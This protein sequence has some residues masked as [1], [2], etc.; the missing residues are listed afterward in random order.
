L[1][2]VKKYISLFGGDPDN[3][4]VM[5]QS[6]GAASIMHHITSYGGPRNYWRGVRAPFKKAIIQSPGFFPLADDKT[7]G[8]VFN[9][10][11]NITE[12]NNLTELRTASEDDL[13]KANSFMVYN[14]PYG[15]FVFG[16]AMD[17]ELIPAPPG[18]LLKYGM[19]W[20]DLQ[21]LVSHVG[22]EGLLFTPPWIQ[23]DKDLRDH[24]SLLLPTLDDKDLN[25]TLALYTELP[26]FKDPLRSNVQ[27]VATALA[28]VAVTC[29]TAYLINALGTWETSKYVFNV[30]SAFHG[31]DAFYTVS[32][33][34]HYC[35]HN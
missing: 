33:L 30:S 16:P 29:N 21:I 26:S 11:L 4:T 24:I 14:A 28:E 6:A 18:L 31:L 15:S 23:S 10:I 35:D 12:A 13:A 5:G 7:E 19:H 25:D 32:D 27:R 34:L 3:V 22:N 8:K 20:K 17:E 2:W 9:Q 1:E